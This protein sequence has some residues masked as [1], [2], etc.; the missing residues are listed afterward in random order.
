M[1]RIEL[2][3]K[4]SLRLVAATTCFPLT[5]T[6]ELVL[7]SPPLPFSP[8]SKVFIK[9][10]QREVDFLVVPHHRHHYIMQHRLTLPVPP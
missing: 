10:D 4:W 6:F 9:L 3:I 7:F 5:T 8:P 2:E 1:I